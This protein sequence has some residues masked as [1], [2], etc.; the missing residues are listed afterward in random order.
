MSLYYWITFIL[1]FPALLF[2]ADYLVKGASSLALK[3]HIS[4]ALIGFTIVA[5]GTS[6]P[7]LLVSIQSALQGEA[8]MALGNAIGSNIANILLILAI[9]S[10]VRTVNLRNT[11]KTNDILIF[12]IASLFIGFVLLFPVY[13]RIAAIF[14]LC[15]FCYILYQ[16]WTSLKQQTEEENNTSRMTTSMALISFILGLMGLI[17]GSSWLVRG[18]QEL[19]LLIGISPVVVGLIFFAIG[20]SLPE[21]AAAAFAVKNGEHALAV[22]NIAGSNIFNGL[23]VLP[24]AGIIQPFAIEN[25]VRIRDL[26]ILLISSLLFAYLLFKGRSITKT[27]GMIFL[28]FYG[29]WVYLVTMTAGV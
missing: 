22:G 7:E 2:G 10:F 3:M 5:F 14:S 4:P 25:I 29:L 23:L 9:A 20:T 8:S 17:V 12:S 24:A 21:V 19:A 26:P 1:G 15:F 6:A 13:G 16:S 27:L 18:G 28:A 11:Y